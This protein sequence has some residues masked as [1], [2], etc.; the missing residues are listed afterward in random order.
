MRER[1]KGRKIERR[2]EG[3]RMRKSKRRRNSARVEREGERESETV[4]ECYE[5]KRKETNERQGGAEG[6]VVG[7][8]RIE[9]EGWTMGTR[10]G[11]DSQTV[12]NRFQN[13]CS[14]GSLSGWRTSYSTRASRGR[15]LGFGYERGEAIRREE[16]GNEAGEEEHSFQLYTKRS[17]R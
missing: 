4:R 11:R 12:R 3:E 10:Q 9:N 6:G 2:E 17:E 15:Q 8:R 1:E 16:R 14:L 13:R 7:G 5:K